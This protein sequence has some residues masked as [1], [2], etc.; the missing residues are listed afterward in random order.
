MCILSN[1][2]KENISL[3]KDG[4]RSDKLS[5][6]CV[7]EKYVECLSDQMRDA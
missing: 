5:I 4:G 3:Y 2:S 6:D 1:R 7:K